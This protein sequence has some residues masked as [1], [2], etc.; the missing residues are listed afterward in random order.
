MRAWKG[1]DV[2]SEGTGISR[3]LSENVNLLGAML[4]EAIR[5]RYGQETL[6][7]VE[8]LRLLCKAAGTRGD[9]SLRE[10]A[11]EE[12]ADLDTEG[13]VELLRAFTAFFHL[14]NQA[15]KQEIVRINRERARA[16][17]SEAARPESIGAILDELAGGGASLGEVLEVFGRL[18]IQPTLTAHPTEARRRTVL[19]KQRRI[20]ELL[21]RLRASE[22][23]PEEEEALLDAIY[24]EIVLL[25]ATDEIRPERPEVQDEVRQGLHFL[26]GVIW[27]TVPRIHRDAHRA[28]RRHYDAEPDLPA[29]LR[30]RS[31]IGSDRDG[32]PNVT[33]DVTRWTFQAH[34]EA[35]LQGHIREMEVLWDELSLSR[36][37]VAVPEELA[38]SLERDARAQPL[39]EEREGSMAQEPFRRKVGHIL[40]RLRDLLAGGDG[41]GYD[42]A[43]YRAD[44]DLLHR[45]LVETGF[46]AVARH[47]Q[48]RRSRILAS[49]FGF[50]LAALD[51]RQHSAVHEGVVA[52]L[53]HAAGVEEDYAGLDEPAR[54]EVLERELRSPRPLLPPGATPPDEVAELLEAFRVVRAQA[55]EEPEAVG[56]WIVSMTHSVSDVLEPMLLA[57]E[58]GSWTLEDGRVRSPLDFV[59]L[60]ETVDDLE[61]APERLEALFASEV[62]RL[63]LEARGG[64]QEVM[65]GYS[66]SNKDGGYWA[67]N[68]ALHEG[69][70]A[71]GR[72]CR[73]H[74][75]DLR[76]FHGRGGTVGRGG[77]R[78][79]RAILAMPPSV[80]NGRIRI[81][82]QGEVISFRYALPDLA[83][84]HLEQVVSAV[85]RTVTGAADVA[86]IPEDAAAILGEVA[87]RSREAYRSLI[88][89][90]GFWP[91]YSTVTPIEHISRLPIAS[92]P[93]SRGSGGLA[94]ED[95]RAIPWSFAWIQVRYLVP[96]W[97]GTGAGLGSAVADPAA[98]DVLAA[99]YRSS[100]FFR[101]VVENARR[102]MARARPEIAGLYDRLAGAEESSPFHRRILED[103]HRGREALL[104]ITGGERLLDSDPVIQRSI[105]LRNPYTDVLN[106]IQIELLRRERRGE[107]SGDETGDLGRALLLSINGIAAA[108]QSTG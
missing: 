78:A 77:G 65:L 41:G 46:E 71:L 44:L 106:L 17:G 47:G 84:R 69:Q 75:V 70:D 37:Q 23:T 30:Y 18:D 43:G 98:A 24:D 100:L 85:I 11:G 89:D 51:V 20:A 31:W 56:S 99:L 97:F 22:P 107:T 36:R 64:L 52:W 72:T 33:A 3:P 95:L 105:E 16:G 76:L 12:V 5:D 48:L 55:T 8:K 80:H 13:L 39:P 96:G 29:F 61:A 103:F 6:D 73:R 4:G 10:R 32:N 83:R 82:E 14:V 63:H 15:E 7:R 93:V 94:F 25:L 104:R 9:P 45:A 42:A 101:T 34:R 108:M 62:Y 74:G 92:R 53:L 40:V 21:D 81:T 26:T 2:E 38:A 19:Q 57:K 49:T 54:R 35:A 87:D 91:W 86:P 59:P 50:H 79:N 60:F 67:A 58:T 68:H 1:L 27:D 66:D 102:E 28:L 90:E 88:D